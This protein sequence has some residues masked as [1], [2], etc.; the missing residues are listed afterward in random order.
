MARSPRRRALVAFAAGYVVV[1]LVS[2]F[3]FE[4]DLPR[5]VVSSLFPA[6]GAA[7]GV[8]IANRFVLRNR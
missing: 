3:A 6:I 8:Y 5:A 4:Y 2:L 1:L 7:V